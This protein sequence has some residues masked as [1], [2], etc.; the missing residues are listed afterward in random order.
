[1]N[2]QA[3]IREATTELVGAGIGTAKLDAEL[4][5]SH[6]LRKPR[7]YLHA[8]TDDEI[9]ERELEI[10]N[11]RLA[12]RIDRVPLAYILGH[13]EFYGRRFIVNPSVLIPRPESEAIIDTLKDLLPDTRALPGHT[14]R[15]VDVGTGSGCLGITAKLEFPELDVTLADISRHALKVA[16]KN[17]EALHA[18][19][20][21][22]KSDLLQSYVLPPDIIVANLPYVDESWERSLE[23]NHEPA[24]ALFARQ[25]GLAFIN[26]LIEQA[27]DVLP[28]EGL[29]L[30][31]ADPEQHQAI[32]AKARVHHL[33]HVLTRDYCVAY[34]KD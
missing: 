20:S 23:T 4:M 17:T 2:V 11:S 10:A 24:E 3:W 15:L 18:H 27:S 31:E 6:T 7:T 25:G 28:M 29:L 34:K 14:I 30:L 9:S 16:E 1:M 19:V 32:Q 22:L 5:L 26:K 8:H 12:L 21:L 33:S 13:K